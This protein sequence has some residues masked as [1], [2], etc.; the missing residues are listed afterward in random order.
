LIDYERV[1]ARRA[2]GD[3]WDAIAADLGLNPEQLRSQYRR[4]HKQRGKRAPKSV[5]AT[6]SETTSEERTKSLRVTLP[7]KVTNLTELIAALEVDMD[8]WRV[9]SFVGNAWQGQTPEGVETFLQVKAQFERDKARELAEWRLA[10]EEI[11]ELMRSHAPRYEPIAFDS[12]AL[13]GAEPTLYTVH[14]YD[15]H[16]GM[17]AW[18][19]E[20]GADYDIRIARSDY[21]RAADH[22]TALAPLY[23]PER[24]LIVIGHDM[25][26]VDTPGINRRGGTTTSGTPQDVDGRIAKQFTTMARCA[27][28]LID[29][30]RRLGVPVDVQMVGGNHDRETVFKLGVVLDAWYRNDESVTVV[31]PPAKR[32]YYGYGQNAFMLTHGEEYRRHRDSLPLIFATECPAELWVQ[33]RYRE[34]LTGHN[35]IKLEGRY[36]PT[37]DAS[38]T[39]GIRTRSLPGLTPE[40]AWHTESGYKHTRAATAI[41]Y[42]RSGGVAGLHEFNLW[43]EGE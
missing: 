32:S 12:K 40:D 14:I 30:A 18:G 35:H 41:A 22:L 24:V 8:D 9:R 25:G 28:H 6:T 16:L 15:P 7:T 23:N 11:V 17:L 1:S 26:H 21:A 27:V 13:R 34:I 2:A 10:G 20:T 43:S 39:R 38:E 36:W 4:A 37:G 29:R 31:N 5:S 3:G 33:S 42:R 19:P